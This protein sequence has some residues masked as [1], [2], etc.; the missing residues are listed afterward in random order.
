[1]NSLWLRRTQ[2]LL[3]SAA[4]I[5]AAWWFT[6]IY[7]LALNN[8]QWLTGWVLVFLMTLLALYNTRKKISFLPLGNNRI[9]LQIHLY[10]GLVTLV[11]FLLHIHWRWPSGYLELY[12]AVVFVL[13]CLSGI[14]GIWMSRR[15]SRR[16]THQGEQLLFERIPGFALHL[17]ESAEDLLRQS[18][19]ATESTTLADFYTRN[20]AA[21]FHRPVFSL[22]HVFQFS[23]RYIKLRNELKAHDRYMNNQELEFS[24]QMMELL[25]QKNYLDNQYTL[26]MLLKS[27]LFIHI[28]L[29]Y[30]LVLILLA[31]IV[32]VY[33][34]GAV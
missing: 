7:Q 31:H 15:F 20:L 30:C 4:V 29:T 1:M 27:W 25:T 11:I 34:F 8:S 21:Y 33:G 10:T 26:Q 14:V 6:N 2:A 16:L 9:W 32:L 3:A 19:D 12:L 13:I 18:I 24:Q 17:R 22:E 5:G 28:P 23:R